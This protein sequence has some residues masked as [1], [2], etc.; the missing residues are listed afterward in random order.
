MSPVDESKT[1]KVERN[2]FEH[3]KGSGI[4]ISRIDNQNNGVTYGESFEIRIPKKLTST[5][6]EKYQRK[7]RQDAIKCAEE[8]FLALKRHGTQFSRI[9]ASIQQEAAIAW[10]MLDPHGIS[11]IEAAKAAILHLRPAGGR[12]TLAAVLRELRES[13]QARFEAKTLSEPTNDDFRSKSLKIEAALGARSIHEINAEDIKKWLTQIEKVGVDGDGKVLKQR[14]IRNYRNTLSEIFAH[15][16]AKQYIAQNPF[17]RFSKEDYKALGGERPKTDIDN[18]KILKPEE[19]R[20][21]LKAACTA[22]HK[23]ILGTVVLRLFCGMR[24]GE[25]SKI[26]W[27]DIHWSIPEPYVH[28]SAR[29]AKK[30]NIR[31]IEIPS[32]LL[33]WIKFI[34]PP[35]EGRVAPGKGKLKAYANKFS[36]LSIDAGFFTLKENGTKKSSWG[37]NDTRHSYASYLYSIN[38]DAIKTSA[39]LGHQQGDQ[40]LFS[41]YRSIANKKAGEEYFNIRPKKSAEA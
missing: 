19:V 21:L 29:I 6:R 28:V 39:Q 9:P 14:T 31:H 15:A 17:D 32:N 35:A 40:M 41:H 8:R 4:V 33:A 11:L 1:G 3:P 37:V 24:T 7:T 23:P 12:V 10:E 2:T 5:K 27:R 20:N 13:K 18:I 26:D 38:G 16:F 36:K 34:N 30:R 25:V 22:K